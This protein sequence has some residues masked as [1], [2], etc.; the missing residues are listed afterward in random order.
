VG[1]AD[2]ARHGAIGALAQI[3]FTRRPRT[4]AAV[5]EMF[6]VWWFAFGVGVTGLAGFASAGLFPDQIAAQIGF[7][8]GNPFEFEVASANLAFGILGL[9]CIRY[10]RQ[11]WEATA[12][13]VTVFLFGAS[14]GHIH[15]YLAFGN[16][17]PDNVGPVLWTDIGVQVILI[18]A[19]IALRVAQRDSRAGADPVA[20]RDPAWSR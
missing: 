9:L 5:L 7:P 19:L 18:V 8:P 12:I 1:P 2:L 4:G 11:F 20:T 3:V 6:L 14:Y 10:R 13:G 15:Q 17:H 16:D